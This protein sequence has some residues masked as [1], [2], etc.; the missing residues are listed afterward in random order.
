MIGGPL[1]E[2]AWWGAGQSL[3][4]VVHDGGEGLQ[5]GRSER[6]DR[7]GHS[8]RHAVIE[9]CLP[10]LLRCDF[11]EFERSAED[12][13]ENGGLLAGGQ[14]L[15]AAQRVDLTVVPVGGECDCRDRGDVTRMKWIVA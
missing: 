14:C 3:D 8:G 2:S 6:H 4:G 7:V 15:R 12:F 11:D 5:R 9:N 13:A 1:A 10:C